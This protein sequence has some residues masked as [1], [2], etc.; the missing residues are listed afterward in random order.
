MRSLTAWKSSIV[1]GTPTERAIAIRCSTALVEPPSTI[2]TT[3]AF[4]KAARV[5]MSRGLRSSSSRL[6]IAAPARRHSSS[7]AGSS[8]GVDEL[9]GS[10]MPSAS[11][12]D[13]I[14]FAVY[15][16]PHAPAPGQAWRTM[17][18]AL[19]LVDALR[20]ELA[21]AL[22]RGDD[23]ERSARAARARAGSCRRRP[24]A[25]GRFTRP[26]AIRQ[27]GMFLSQPGIE[28][29]ASYHCAHITVSIE[30][31]IRSRDWSE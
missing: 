6:R 28:T 31:A 26:I 23:V 19:V 12:A 3:I 24:S 20:D 18:R 16:P 1:S 21:V 27:P 5:M 11:I 15:M 13:A 29:F 22:E 8:A 30:S 7:F 2:T 4:S 14:V 25:T 9:Y 10:D 17:S